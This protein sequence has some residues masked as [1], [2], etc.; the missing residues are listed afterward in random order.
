MRNIWSKIR[1]RFNWSRTKNLVLGHKIISLIVLVVIIFAGYKIYSNYTN[2]SGQTR[3][4]ISA[5]QTGTIISSVSGSGQVSASSQVDVQAKASGDVTS[6]N[7]ISG[8]TVS[9]GDLIAQIDSRSAA[10]D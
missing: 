6:V 5:V 4:V 1:A 9:V 7:V 2:T 3:Y 8:Q 10:L